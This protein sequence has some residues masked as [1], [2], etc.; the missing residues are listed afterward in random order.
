MVISTKLLDIP[1]KNKYRIDSSKNDKLKFYYNNKEHNKTFDNFLK[2]LNSKNY[3]EAKKY[4]SKNL[5]S[6][7]DIKKLNDSL[8]TEQN[9]NNIVKVNF[10]NKLKANS[11]LIIN[12][13]AKNNILH[14]NLVFEPDENSAWKIF[15]I[16][17]E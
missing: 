15:E 2:A 16:T 10:D 3:Y 4:L 6:S 5:R 14:M 17:K 12:E 13:S 9:F 8:S 11:L 7:L 1:I